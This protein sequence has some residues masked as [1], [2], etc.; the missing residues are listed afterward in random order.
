MNDEREGEREGS[1]EDN[2]PDM[3]EKEEESTKKDN[4]MPDEA[5]RHESEENDSEEEMKEDG[6]NEK[7]TTKTKNTNNKKQLKKVKNA[8]TVCGREVKKEG[9]IRC[10]GCFRNCHTLCAGYKNT[11]E[12]LE[13]KDQTPAYECKECNE[14]PKRGRPKRRNSLPDRVI[15]K[16]K[17]TVEEGLPKK[18]SPLKKRNKICDANPEV[19]DGEDWKSEKTQIKNQIQQALDENRHLY[20]ILNTHIPASIGQTQKEIKQ[21]QQV[22]EENCHLKERINEFIH[23][24]VGVNPE[25]KTEINKTEINKTDKSQEIIEIPLINLNGQTLYKEDL[26]SLKE[27]QWLTGRIID[28]KIKAIL[29]ENENIIKD[30]KIRYV[31]TVNMV[32]LNNTTDKTGIKQII[33][34]N[35]ITESNWVLYIINNCKIRETWNEGDHWSLLIYSKEHHQYHHFDSIRGNPNAESAKD[36]ILNMLD[37][38]S[39]IEGNLPSYREEDCGKQNNGYDCGIFT[40]SNIAKAIEHIGNKNEWTDMTTTQEEADVL[41]KLMLSQIEFEIIRRKNVEKVKNDNEITVINECKG[42]RNGRINEKKDTNNNGSNKGNIS[43]GNTRTIDNKNEQVNYRKGNKG[44]D[45][46]KQVGNN[47]NNESRETKECWY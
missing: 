32:L 11:K 33:N 35:K 5:K 15:Q 37:K 21:A 34:D 2:E 23:K 30:N 46:N 13:R 7:E 44:D 31:D 4:K 24:S 28:S 8:C 10:A 22:F 19:T 45:D 9:S 38:D 14:K 29:K 20:H 47:K 25:S 17:R 12:Y 27:K 42:S 18:A 1:D 26:N 41:R 3:N 16:R 40:I 43:N 39:F 6:D 36:L